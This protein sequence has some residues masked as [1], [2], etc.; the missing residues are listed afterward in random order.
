MYTKAEQLIADRE[1]QQAERTGAEGLEKAEYILFL[2]SG[3]DEMTTNFRNLLDSRRLRE[4][5]EGKVEFQGEFYDI[6]TAD[7]LQ[8]VEKLKGAAMERLQQGDP[9][10][11]ETSFAEAVTL[12]EENGLSTAAAEVLRVSAEQR[13]D[14]YLNL[15]NSAYEGRQWQQAD[16]YYAEAVEIIKDERSHLGAESVDKL[17]KIEI[18][19][20]LAA[21]N[22]HKAEAAIAEKAGDFKKAA[23]QYQLIVSTVRQSRYGSDTILMRLVAEAEAEAERVKQQALVAAGTEY[24]LEN[25]KEIFRRHYPGVHEPALQSPRVKFMGE[26]NG[27]LVFLLSCIELIQRHS[28][29]FLLPYQYDSKTREWSIHREV[30]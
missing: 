24:L 5:L 12:A 16:E 27:K 14:Y 10:G 19:Q 29:E 6:R 23:D 3:R 4:G 1:F 8:N 15:G 25:Y 9:G 18:L 13:L 26:S 11:A 28:N 2:R 21:A 20:I 7:T 22:N 17:E 30:K